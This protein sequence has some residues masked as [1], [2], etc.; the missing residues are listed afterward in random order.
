MK[1]S[2]PCSACCISTLQQRIKYCFAP[3]Q[4]LVMLQTLLVIHV[5]I[6]TEKY[7]PRGASIERRGGLCH[8]L[9]LTIERNIYTCV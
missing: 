7:D 2:R 1:L 4:S 6:S 9:P 5:V 8:K 3:L